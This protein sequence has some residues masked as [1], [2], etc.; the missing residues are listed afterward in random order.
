MS[1]V[2]SFTGCPYLRSAQRRAVPIH[3]SPLSWSPRPIVQ[4]GTVSLFV[5]FSDRRVG[6]I[7]SVALNDTESS[8]TVAS[9][10]LLSMQQPCSFNRLRRS[11]PC[12]ML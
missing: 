4:R 6:P 3:V 7:D 9:R 1:T 5:R 12:R 8:H 11:I 10:C 2:E